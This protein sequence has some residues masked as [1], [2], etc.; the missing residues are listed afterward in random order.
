MSPHALSLR[1]AATATAMVAATAMAVVVP[2]ATAQTTACS[3]HSAATVAPVVELYTSEGCNSCPPADRWLSRLKAD[4]TLVGLAFHVDY[5]DR[6]GW[7]D[8][9][10]SPAYTQRQAQQQASNGARFSYTPQ[11]VL[12]GRDHPAWH[13]QPAPS[14]AK[15]RAVAPVALALARDGERFTATVQPGANAPPRL[16]AFWAVTEDGHVTAVKAGENEGATLP[17]DFVV[18]QYLPV[19]AWASQPGTPV[20]LSFTPAPANAQHPRHVNLVVLDAATGK[21]V[22]ALKLACQ[23]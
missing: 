8:R 7:K 21:P 14:S 20:T 11:V 23:G 3:A 17:H 1:S 12:D 22:Q 16:A 19:S 10:A 15:A 2:L 4:P 18:R 9:F 13:S 5:W 6:L